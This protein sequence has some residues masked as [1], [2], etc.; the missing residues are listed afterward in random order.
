MEIRLS[1]TIRKSKTAR[2]LISKV[3]TKGGDE[4]VTSFRGLRVSKDHWGVELLGLLDEL[5]VEL[6]SL[7]TDVIASPEIQKIQESMFSLSSALY[8]GWWEGATVVSVAELEKYT[9]DLRKEF[10]KGRDELDGFLI[11]RGKA[12]IQAHR[13]RV[14]CR[15]VERRLVTASRFQDIPVE[16]IKYFNRISDVLFTVAWSMTLDE[17]L[18]TWRPPDP[19]S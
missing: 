8:S 19:S 11:P 17:N 5:N 3:T 18:K 16:V 4:G 2:P 10:L 7:I 9:S 14:L 13:V 6:G 1:G 12:A 15:K